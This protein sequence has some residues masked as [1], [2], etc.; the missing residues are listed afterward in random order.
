MMVQKL[1]ALAQRMDK[2]VN[3]PFDIVRPW[4]V[5][6]S[7][8]IGTL[9]LFLQARQHRFAASCV[10]RCCEVTAVQA[11]D[12]VVRTYDELQA[13]HYDP[14][15]VRPDPIDVVPRILAMNQERRQLEA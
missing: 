12:A 6:M 8:R 1:E 4:Q 2:V 10:A 7:D 13:Q 11:D 5:A 14:Q 15:R 3:I 9:A